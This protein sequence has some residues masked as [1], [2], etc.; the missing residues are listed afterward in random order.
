M[1][2][3]HFHLIKNKNDIKLMIY[4]LPVFLTDTKIARKLQHHI[5]QRFNSLFV[6]LP[7]KV[8]QIQE[9]IQTHN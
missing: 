6:L 5:N 4:Y 1:I 8:I 3:I 9:Q 7:S 2:Q